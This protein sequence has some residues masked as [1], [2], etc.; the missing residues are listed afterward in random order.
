MWITKLKIAGAVLV[1]ASLLG[2]GSG[3]VMNGALARRHAAVEETDQEKTAAKVEEP[4]ADGRLPKADLY[5]DPLPE[6]AVAR[7]GTTRY[8]LGN[9]V[10]SLVFLPDGKSL[11][12]G[13][14]SIQVMDLATGKQLRRFRGVGILGG[15][16]DRPIRTYEGDEIAPLLRQTTFGSSGTIDLSPNGELL[17]GTTGGGTVNFWNSKTA[18]S[19]A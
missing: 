14:D 10:T 5:G 19:C 4:I 17:A 13:G 8:W 18:S 11:L 1:A 7:L 6:G 2:V 16:I 3:M 15:T 12:S 9:Q